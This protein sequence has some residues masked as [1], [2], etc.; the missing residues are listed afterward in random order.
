MLAR[1]EA[2]VLESQ[3]REAEARL[4]RERALE[5]DILAPLRTEERAVKD[6]AVASA[7]ANLAQAEQSGRTAV[8]RAY[9][10]ADDAIREKADEL[11][12]ESRGPNPKFGTTFTYGNTTYSLTAD[13]QTRAELTASRVL[14]EDA[15]N[16]LAIRAQAPEGDTQTLLSDTD[17]DLRIIETFLTDLARVVNKYIQ[18]DSEALTVY[19]GY[20]TSVSSARSAISTARSDVL[21]VRKE[22]INCIDSACRILA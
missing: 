19:E 7:E 6:T 2:G 9:T 10:Y 16:R 12:Y 8:A 1:L 18:T 14:V 3:V 21:A 22:H 15:L 17:A 13:A 11:F 5:A 20:Q 4:A